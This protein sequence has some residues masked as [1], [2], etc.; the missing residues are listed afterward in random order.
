MHHAYTIGDFHSTKTFETLETAADGTEISRK[1]LRNPGNGWISEMRATQP[2]FLEI[3]PCKVARKEN[4]LENFSKIWVY[5]MT[6]SSFVEIYENAALFATGS[7]RKFNNRGFGGMKS[8]PYFLS[9][10]VVFLSFEICQFSSLNLVPRSHSVFL[11]WPWE[12]WV[13][14]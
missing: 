8:A 4:F 5:H 14:D 6:L 11:P 1:S 13:R 3:F 9:K 2:T 10:L 7:S 12:I